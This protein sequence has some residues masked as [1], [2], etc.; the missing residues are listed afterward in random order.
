MHLLQILSLY[1][2]VYQDIPFALSDIRIVIRSS[3][4]N[5]E[6]I[7]DG[8]G[9]QQ[10]DKNLDSPSKGQGAYGMIS[11]IVLHGKCTSKLTKILT[12]LPKGKEHM[13]GFLL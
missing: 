5:Q 10:T 6:E 8:Q 12:A 7:T 11:V 3:V 4:E 13:V 1:V 9:C 2:E